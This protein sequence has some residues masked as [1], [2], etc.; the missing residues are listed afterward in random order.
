L[1]D[2]EE[3]QKK[4]PAVKSPP[5]KKAPKKKAPAKKLLPT[6]SAVA[7]ARSHQ[8]GFDDDSILIYHL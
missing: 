8:N 1:G 3:L 2:E 5:V 4:P 6:S 7:R